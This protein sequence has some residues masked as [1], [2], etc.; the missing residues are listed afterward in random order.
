[1]RKLV[2]AINLSI[3]GTLDHTKQTVDEDLDPKF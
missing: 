2:Y 3:D 1:M